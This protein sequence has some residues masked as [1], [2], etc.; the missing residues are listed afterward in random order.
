MPGSCHKNGHAC[1]HHSGPSEPIQTATDPICGMAVDVTN[2]K[3]K[4][5]HKGQDYYFCSTHCLAKFREDPAGHAISA[6]AC[7]AEKAPGQVA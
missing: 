1:E 6:T 2:A 4:H 7:A 3:H 5:R